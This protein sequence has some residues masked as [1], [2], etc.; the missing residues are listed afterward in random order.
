[1]HRNLG[2][3]EMVDYITAAKWLKSKPWV[4]KDKLLITGHSYGGYM[5][6]LALTKGADYFDYGIAGAPVTS[7][8]LYDTHYT[9]RYMDTPQDNP[10]SEERRVGKECVSTCR[11]RGAPYH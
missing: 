5:T 11:S 3:W 2:H 7:W 10:R 1:M 8:E 4:A 9:E 6:C